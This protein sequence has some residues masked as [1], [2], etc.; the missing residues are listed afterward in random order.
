MIALDRREG[1]A[2]NDS[3]LLDE[4]H[5][6]YALLRKGKQSYHLVEISSEAG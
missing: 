4:A 1:K 6:R 2:A 3:R 5:G